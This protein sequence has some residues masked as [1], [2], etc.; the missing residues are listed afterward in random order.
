MGMILVTGQPGHGKTAWAIDYAFQLKKEGRE[1]YAHGI[2]DFDYERAGFHFLQ[3]PTKWQDLPDG[4]V[5]LLDECYTVFPNRNP[6]AKVPDHVE[7]TARHRHRGFDFILIAQQG[8]QLDPFLRGLYEQHIHVRQTSVIKS[9][10]KLKR[11]N[12]YQGN[13]NGPCNDVV[14]WIRPDYVFQ[15][16][17][18]TTKIT[19]K[20]HVPMWL[21]WVAAGV[22]FVL[23]MLFTIKWYYASKIEGFRAQHET[24]ILTHQGAAPAGRDFERTDGADA[25]KWRTAADYAKAHLPR[26]AT[27]PWTAPVFDGRSPVTDPQLFC[28]SSRPG[29]DASGQHAD[30]SCRCLTEQGTAYEISEGECRRIALRGQVYNPYRV[31]S[32]SYQQAPQPA[33]PSPPSPRPAPPTASQPKQSAE[34]IARYG[35]M[36]D[37]TPQRAITLSS[38][39]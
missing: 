31:A 27:M 32:N 4:S 25:P 34:D 12:Q 36:R 38:S 17:T 14:D 20:R 11:W 37:G 29:K 22:A 24:S 18:S 9:K 2:K 8:L 33:T 16:Y 6:G 1:I 19:T 23:V 26:F 21:R 15:Y 10:T 3:D 35:Y 30:G 39:Y 5:I 28:M 13:V 7:A